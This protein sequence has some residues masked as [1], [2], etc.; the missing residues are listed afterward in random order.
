MLSISDTVHIHTN[1]HTHNCTSINGTCKHSPLQ[2]NDLHLI[3]IIE[4][5]QFL[6][7]YHWLKIQKITVIDS[8]ATSCRLTSWLVPSKQHCLVFVNGSEGDIA[9]GRR[10]RASGGRGGP[11]A[12]GRWSNTCLVS[13]PLLHLAVSQLQYGK[14]LMHVLILSKWIIEVLNSNRAHLKF[15]VVCNIT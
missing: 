14:M 15:S 4:L 7:A 6:W 12:C 9:T 13:L 2:C 10:S 8:T 5:S 1:I 11:L 3:A